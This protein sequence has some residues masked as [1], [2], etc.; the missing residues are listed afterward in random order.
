MPTHPSGTIGSVQNG[1]ELPNVKLVVVTESEVF[2]QKQRRPR[3][4]AKMSNAER[5]KSYQDLQPGDYV[6]H[7][8]HGIGK[9][10]GIETLNVGGMHKDY[11]NI[12]YAGN[13][14][15]YVPI[16]QIDLVQKYVGG[17]E[18]APKVYSLSGSEWSKVKN[19]VKSSVKDLAADLIKLYAKRQATKGYKLKRFLRAGI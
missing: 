17:E 8:N 4:V 10:L 14:K 11:L 7:V 12:H 9:Y 13:D 15:L 2:T 16:E 1:F 5:I 3:R 19:R 18:K 6:V